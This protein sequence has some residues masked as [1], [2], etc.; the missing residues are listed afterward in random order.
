MRDNWQCVRCHNSDV[1]DVHHKSYL[2][3]K[4][5]WDHPDNMLETL[6]RYCHSLEHGQFP[7]IGQA[8]LKSWEKRKLYG[9]RV[10]FIL[11]LESI[12]NKERQQNELLVSKWSDEVHKFAMSVLSN[13]GSR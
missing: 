1:C 12:A 13:K 11:T 7:F 2:T 3:G 8:E 4:A 9:Q 5:L 6:C 10:R